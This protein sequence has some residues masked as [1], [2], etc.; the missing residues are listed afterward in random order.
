[1]W[2]WAKVLIREQEATLISMELILLCG[3]HGTN[4]GNV[5]AK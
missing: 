1:M 3:T 5:R 2:I 4:L